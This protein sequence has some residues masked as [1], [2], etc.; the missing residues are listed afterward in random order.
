MGF[1]NFISCPLVIVLHS[2]SCEN[3]LSEL[4]F[5]ISKKNVSMV[6]PSQEDKLFCTVMKYIFFEITE[7]NLTRFNNLRL[8]FSG[9]RQQFS[10]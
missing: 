6:K 4:D 2:D 1:F 8:C 7:E 5:S 3:S 10:I 9:F